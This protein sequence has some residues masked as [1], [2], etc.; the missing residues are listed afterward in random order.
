MAAEYDEHGN[1]IYPEGFDVESGEWQAGFEAQREAWDREYSEARACYERHVAQAVRARDR[2]T[3]LNPS[4]SAQ[5]GPDHAAKMRRSP[6][7]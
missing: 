6:V 3:E 1:Y 7:D 4:S 2:S 5:Q